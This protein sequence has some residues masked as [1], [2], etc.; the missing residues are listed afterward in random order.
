MELW[1]RLVKFFQNERKKI[2]FIS[3]CEVLST[4]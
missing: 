2:L 3:I 4:L 1:N